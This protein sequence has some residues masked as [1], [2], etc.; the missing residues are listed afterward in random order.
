MKLILSIP[1]ALINC[2]KTKCAIVFY[3]INLLNNMLELP[4]GFF[5]NG[6][7]HDSFI[8]KNKFNYKCEFSIRS[9]T[10]LLLKCSIFSLSTHHR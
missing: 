6:L 10:R 9:V 2:F 4:K 1:V 7:V 5:E 3:V 8:D